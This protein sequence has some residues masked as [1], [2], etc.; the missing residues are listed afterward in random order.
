MK[1]LLLL[2]AATLLATSCKKNDLPLRPVK[3]VP[4]DTIPG[5]IFV[6]DPQDPKL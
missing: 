4:R 2:V 1:L 3:A 5:V 6:N